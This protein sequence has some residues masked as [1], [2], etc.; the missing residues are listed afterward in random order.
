MSMLLTLMELD[1][2]YESA[3]SAEWLSRKALIRNIKNSG[4][5]YNFEKYSDEQLYSIWERIQ[6]EDAERI[7]AWEYRNLSDD[8][9]PA[10]CTECGIRLNSNGLCPCCDDGEE[11]Y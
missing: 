5:N 8:D 6:K 3:P 10:T 4:R 1:E 11:D 2:L 9:R 7:A